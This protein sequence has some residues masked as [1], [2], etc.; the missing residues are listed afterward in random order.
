M[1]IF[2]VIVFMFVC[3]KGIEVLNSKN[4]YDIKYSGPDKTAEEKWFPFSKKFQFFK[5]KD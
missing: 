3:S 5:K 2:F 4:S 1:S